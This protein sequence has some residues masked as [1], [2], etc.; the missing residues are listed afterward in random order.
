MY[1]LA[2]S[3]AASSEQ[4]RRLS[5]SRYYKIRFRVAE[6]PN[7]PRDVLE[8]LA[9]DRN[10]DVR[11]AVATNTACPRNLVRLLASDGDI[12][13]RHGLAQDIGTPM[14]IL[15]QL[16]HDEN[17]WVSSEAKKTLRILTSWT[18]AEL[19]ER[20]E[21]I[22][23]RKRSIQRRLEREILPRTQVEPQSEDAPGFVGKELQNTIE[24]ST[25]R[26]DQAIANWQ[27]N[28]SA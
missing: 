13:V 1:I 21:R 25:G 20:K 7:T 8:R 15:E 19:A 6:N 9:F 24:S 11:V 2:G 4:L 10:H 27:K 18:Q 23:M 5:N 16:R 28:S 22:R 3:P 12:T 14:D 17:A 26:S